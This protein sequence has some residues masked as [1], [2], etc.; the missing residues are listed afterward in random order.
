MLVKPF[1]TVHT[2]EMVLN[3][4]HNKCC[5]HWAVG[6][7]VKDQTAPDNCGWPLIGCMSDKGIYLIMCTAH[8]E[9]ALVDYLCAFSRNVGERKKVGVGCAVPVSVIPTHH[10]G[11]LCAE[12]H[13]F[14]KSVLSMQRFK[15]QT[16][17]PPRT[18]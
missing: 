14:A 12:S 4:V 6:E 7:T 13:V 11:G 2:P 8:A 5:E 15:Q 17:L 10:T 18:Y 3:K 16:L 9:C 1:A